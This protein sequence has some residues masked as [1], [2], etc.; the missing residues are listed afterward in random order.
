MLIGA[1][2]CTGDD[3]VER[4]VVSS[5]S[6]KFNQGWNYK[7]DQSGKYLNT[8]QNYMP[9][10]KNLQVINISIVSSWLIIIVFIFTHIR[11]LL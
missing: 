7:S 5:K 1:S 9:Q 8:I 11:T 3:A 10:S 6:L 2:S 4:V